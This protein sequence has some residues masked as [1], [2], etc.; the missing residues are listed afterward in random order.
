MRR[1]R[2][3]A[4]QGAGSRQRGRAGMSEKRTI[5]WRTL[6]EDLPDEPMRKANGYAVLFDRWHLRGFLEGVVGA[7]LAACLPPHEAPPEVPKLLQ[8]RLP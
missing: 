6:L 1:L 8:G 2:H 4:E 7:G 5:V 3:R